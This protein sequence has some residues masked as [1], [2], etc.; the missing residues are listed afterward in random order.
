MSE[1]TCFAEPSSFRSDGQL[2]EPIAQRCYSF[3]IGRFTPDDYRHLCTSFLDEE[4]VRKLDIDK[5]HRVF[6]E[7]KENAPSIIFI[8]DSDVIFESGQEHGLYRYLLTMLDGLESKSADRVCVMMTAMD[9]GNLPPAVVR[10]GRVE[11]WLEMSLPDEPARLAILGQ[12]VAALPQVLRLPDL[13]RLTAATEGFT[14]ADLKRVIDDGK[15]LYAFE[16]A[17]GVPLK[18]ISDYFLGDVETVRA[19]KKRYAEA[20]ARARANRPPR[21]PWFDVSQNSMAYDDSDDLE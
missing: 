12:F 10:S 9:V 8:D 18:P 2:P 17:T 14:G 19:N 16:R 15:A 5:V 4:R 11:L 13:P 6:H 7:A 3:A 1:G 21:P 20:E